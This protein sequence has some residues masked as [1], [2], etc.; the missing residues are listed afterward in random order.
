MSP[1]GLLDSGDR[2]LEGFGIECL[3]VPMAPKSVRRN[4]RLGMTGRA[5]FTCS[6]A[7]TSTAAAS[8]EGPRQA[9]G[10]RKMQRR[11][12]RFMG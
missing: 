9:S 6:A 8:R 2:F 3:V 12:R 7:E 11:R 4:V 10:T 5:G 1:A